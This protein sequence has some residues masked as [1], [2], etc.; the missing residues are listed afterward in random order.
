MERSGFIAGA[1]K[2]LFVGSPAYYVWV[3]FLLSVI[4]I[5]VSAYIKQ[6][7]RRLIV[8]GMTSYVS[9]GLYIGNFTFLVGVRCCGLVDTAHHTVPNS[10]PLKRS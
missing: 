5:G 3:F 6:L 4:A 10:G 8:T 9:W 2:R 7:R 1:V